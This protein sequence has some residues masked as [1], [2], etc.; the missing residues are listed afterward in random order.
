VRRSCL[1][2][3]LYFALIE[4]RSFLTSKNSGS[5]FNRSIEETDSVITTPAPGGSGNGLALHLTLLAMVG[6]SLTVRAALA[7]RDVGAYCAARSTPFIMP[8]PTI[9]II[10][11]QP[12]CSDIRQKT[13]LRTPK[14][15]GDHP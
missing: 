13:H 3:L 7:L 6:G 12:P 9:C 1:P 4:N 11:K 14:Q 8:K 15:K 10:I 2:R 5:Q